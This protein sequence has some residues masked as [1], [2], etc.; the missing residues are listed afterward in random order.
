MDFLCIVELHMVLPK[1]LIL[2]SRIVRFIPIVAAPFS[3]LLQLVENENTLAL[4]SIDR[5]GYPQATRA[6]A[7]FILENRIVSG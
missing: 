5:F 6:F 1:S 2:Y 3:Y 7:E 4:R